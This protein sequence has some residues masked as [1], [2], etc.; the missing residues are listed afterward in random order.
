LQGC[1]GIRAIR[2]TLAKRHVS[3]L[4]SVYLKNY[5]N[6]VIARTIRYLTMSSFVAFRSL[7]IVEKL[8]DEIFRS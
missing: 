4:V 1:D 5:L 6:L 8:G 7:R 3:R 2:P